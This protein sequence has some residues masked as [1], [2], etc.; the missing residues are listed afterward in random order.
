MLQQLLNGKN[1][2]A[3]E[4]NNEDSSS[5]INPNASSH[6]KDKKE[7]IKSYMPKETLIESN[8]SAKAKSTESHYDMSECSKVE[9]LQQKR[10][11][12]P[13]VE[14]NDFISIADE[15][16]KNIPG[17]EYKP[18]ISSVIEEYFV[19]QDFRPSIRLFWK[20][21]I[22]KIMLGSKLEF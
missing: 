17:Y 8:D 19:C 11:S 14:T 3:K 10:S 12:T 18:F 4:Q 21:G 22:A 15:D 7:N 2:K 9:M 13:E 20:N 5:T 6:D 1:N 16:D